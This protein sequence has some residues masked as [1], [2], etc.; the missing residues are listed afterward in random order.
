MRNVNRFFQKYVHCRELQDIV[1]EIFKDGI[2]TSIQKPVTR[3]DI[4][5]AT[6]TK[7][8]LLTRKNASKCA[9]VLKVNFIFI[10][11]F[12]PEIIFDKIS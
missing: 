10:Y 11:I 3:L 7:I 2:L 4:P 1:K 6:G 8:V 9:T 12:P 5:G